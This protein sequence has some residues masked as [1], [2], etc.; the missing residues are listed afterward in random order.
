LIALFG[1]IALVGLVVAGAVILA[2]SGAH[3]PPTASPSSGAP[4]DLPA[5]SLDPDAPAFPVPSGATLRNA[6]ITGGTGPSAARLAAWTSPLAFD[7]TVA[8]YATLTDPR[9]L[10]GGPPTTT[11]QSAT[12]GFTDASGVLAS[13]DVTI[14][15]TDPVGIAVV[16][17][18]LT[19][20][21]PGPSSAP[22]PTIAFASLPPA[23]ALPPS[24][25]SQLVPAN[26]RLVDAGAVGGT[27]DA[28]FASSSDPATL[29][30]AYQTALA[31]LATGLTSH[32][33][34]GAGG[35]LWEIHFQAPQVSSDQVRGVLTAQGLSGATVTGTSDGFF[36]IQNSNPIANIDQVRTALEA[37][38]GPIDV[39][40]RLTTVTPTGSSIVLDFSTNGHPGE[41]VLSPDPAGGTT[42][43]V[44]VS[45]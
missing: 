27:D 21:S 43:S 22:G 30:A 3:T 7:A 36:L 12:V 4:V 2:A 18:S 34:G 24:F 16:F 28:I 23:T 44:Q 17:T 25:P 1:G 13:A 35:T 15:R 26:S 40:R 41:I 8:F 11:P 33:A 29:A 42:V 32:A 38:L 19:P 37:A 14:A 9:W 31:G 39:Q 20:I 5:P 10:R 45:P 6:Q